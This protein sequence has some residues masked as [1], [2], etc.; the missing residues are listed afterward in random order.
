MNKTGKDLEELKLKFLV[1]CSNVQT[2]RGG[3]T[4]DD[5]DATL[6]TEM[7]VRDPHTGQF[8]SVDKS[9]TVQ[10]TSSPKFSKHF[11]VDTFADQE[12]KFDVF[13]GVAPP[14]R[15]GYVL[16]TVAELIENKQRRF[17]MHSDDAE[18]ATELKQSNCTMRVVS[19]ILADHRVDPAIGPVMQ[20]EVAYRLIKAEV[21]VRCGDLI[22]MD[23]LTK[24][25]ARVCLF[26]SDDPTGKG[27]FKFHS[28]TETIDN[29]HNPI[30][31]TKFIL[32]TTPETLLSWRVFD[33][34]DDE[35]DETRQLGSAV[36]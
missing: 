17:W 27:T 11:M 8:V 25:D 19:K 10:G 33:D 20:P 1:R 26:T 28:Q 2:Q 18:W 29:D 24:S 14:T 31:E 32:E 35:T 5:E 6:W 4:H 23:Y 16:T 15:V 13:A 34:D 7:S 30:F 21:S 3:A 22:K 9:E 12:V 36:K